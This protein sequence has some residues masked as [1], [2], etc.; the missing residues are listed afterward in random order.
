MIRT[1]RVAT[2]VALLAAIAGIT[3]AQDDIAAE[4]GV[5]EI[6]SMIEQHQAD[7]AILFSTL[8]VMIAAFLVFFMQAGFAYVEAG[9]TRAKNA[10]NIMMKNLMDFSI[11]SVAFLAVGYAVMF[12]DTIGGFIGVG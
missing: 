2:A 11:G 3:H 12:G 9:F 7:Q 6:L 5:A 8:W 10:N 4:P 1:L